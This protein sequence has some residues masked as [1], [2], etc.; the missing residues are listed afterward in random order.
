MANKRAS[1][2]L[3]MTVNLENGKCSL[4]TMTALGLKLEEIHSVPGETLPLER[5]CL[6]CVTNKL[7]ETQK[8]Q[9]ASDPINGTPYL[10]G[11][12][13]K[14]LDRWIPLGCDTR[15]AF[16]FLMYPSHSAAKS[17][18]VRRLFIKRYK[19]EM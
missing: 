1:R 18:V 4:Q 16:L 6:R 14:K 9:S 17:M 8:C 11:I 10:Q 5:N 15:R 12:E 19:V 2:R 7:C 13:R 3:E